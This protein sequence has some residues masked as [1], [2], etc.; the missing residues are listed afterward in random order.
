MK[1]RFNRIN[2]SS[3]ELT[4][5]AKVASS[6]DDTMILTFADEDGNL[7]AGIRLSFEEAETLGEDLFHTSLELRP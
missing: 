5:T 4:V 1:G 3:D 2:T 7:C 6:T